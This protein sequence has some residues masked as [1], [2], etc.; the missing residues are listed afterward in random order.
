M[1][2]NDP[3]YDR[4]REQITEM[5]TLDESERNRF[6]Y[7]LRSLYRAGARAQL[8]VGYRRPDAS[9]RLHWLSDQGLLSTDLETVLDELET[10]RE[11]VDALHGAY[12]VTDGEIRSMISEGFPTAFRKA[13]DTPEAGWIHKLIREMDP[14]DWSAVIDFVADPIIGWLREAEAKHNQTAPGE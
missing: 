5:A 7:L 8:D 1:A 6:A 13:I 9:D 14:A 10:L 2:T 3:E 4:L 11:K 12:G